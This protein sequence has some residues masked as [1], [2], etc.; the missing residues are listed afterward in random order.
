MSPYSS[1]ELVSI[2]MPKVHEGLLRRNWQKRVIHRDYVVTLGSE[3]IG[4]VHFGW[5]ASRTE[6]LL[7]LNALVGV[8][9]QALERKLAEIMREEFDPRGPGTIVK[10]LGYLMPEPRFVQWR[11]TYD[12]EIRRSCERM[13]CSRRSRRACSLRN[14]SWTPFTGSAFPVA[15]LLLGKPTRATKLVDCYVREMKGHTFPL[16][17]DYRNFVRDFQ[18]ELRKGGRKSLA[19]AE[20]E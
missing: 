9:N 8:R 11:F 5:V 1:G 12:M 7:E 3:A 18:G 13:G 4:T 17:T 14:S 19:L 15:Y 10:Q 6:P 16:E 2:V 20:F